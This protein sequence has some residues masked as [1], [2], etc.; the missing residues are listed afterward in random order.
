MRWEGKLRGPHV[1]WDVRDA[2]RLQWWEG[3]LCG[4]G[5]WRGSGNGG[6]VSQGWSPGQGQSMWGQ[7]HL[8]HH[9]HL[10]DEAAKALKSWPFPGRHASQSEGETQVPLLL[11]QY[12]ENPLPFS[13]YYF[14][15]LSEAN[16]NVF[17]L[18]PGRV[19][20]PHAQGGRSVGVCDGPLPL[21]P[22]HACA[23]VVPSLPS[24]FWLPYLA[25]WGSER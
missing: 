17:I 2:W 22:P 25:W 11:R 1:D 13:S 21:Q 18:G 3:G 24:S 14:E 8:G 19:R 4:G 23:Y 5:G 16:L 6:R 7:G 15:F 9:V 20:G 10:R 12:L